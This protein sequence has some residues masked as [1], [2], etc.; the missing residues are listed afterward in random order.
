M[1]GVPLGSASFTENFVKDS[2]LDITEGVMKK[3]LDFEDTQAAMFLLRLSFGIVR[4]NHF[5]RTT[6]LSLW[7]EQAKVFDSKVCDTVFQ[8]LGLKPT[9]EACDQA[10]VSTTIGGLEVRR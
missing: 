8:C 9:P 6:P 1:L 2:L 10:S 7:A 3:L 5:M 4:A